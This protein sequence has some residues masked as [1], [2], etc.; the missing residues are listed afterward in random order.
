MTS[1]ASPHNILPLLSLSGEKMRE[2]RNAWNCKSKIT[3]GSSNILVNY[4]NITPFRNPA[5]DFGL[6]PIQGEEAGGKIIFHLNKFPHSLFVAHINLALWCGTR[7]FAS[8]E[9]WGPDALTQSSSITSLLLSTGHH[10]FKL[11]K[12]FAPE[13]H[14]REPKKRC[15][16]YS[17]WN[18][19]SKEKWK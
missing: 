18:N 14:W 16:C 1:R 8:Q 4:C 6:G 2:V 3:T 5:R 10:K 17:F 12:D 13:S 15:K 7:Y 19:L 9:N 11:V